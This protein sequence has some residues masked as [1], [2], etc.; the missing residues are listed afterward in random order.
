[1]SENDKRS[2]E[3]CSSYVFRYKQERK[4]KTMKQA[5][6]EKCGWVFVESPLKG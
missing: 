1:M 2:P 6:N 5:G 3:F 4:R